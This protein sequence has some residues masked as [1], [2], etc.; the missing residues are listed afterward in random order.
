VGIHDSWE[1]NNSEEE[2]RAKINIHRKRSSYIED[3]F[4]KSQNYCSTGD[5]TAE[6]NIHLED[7]VS[8][9]TVRRELLKSKIHDGAAIAKP[10]ITETNDQ[11]KKRWRHDDETW[12]SDKR[13]R[14]IW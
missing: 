6:L 12:T 11:I 5:R 13:K 8:T 4:E 10:L 9:K 14:V 2:Q 7:P 1:N 3:C